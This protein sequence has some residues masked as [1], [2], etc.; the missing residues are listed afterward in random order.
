MPAPI[1]HIAGGALTYLLSGNLNINRWYIVAGVTLLSVLPDIDVLI[2]GMHR[3]FGHSL[4]FAVAVTAVVGG[5]T[6]FSY[7][8][9]FLILLSHLLLDSL[10]DGFNTVSWLF[11]FYIYHSEAPFNDIHSLIKEIFRMF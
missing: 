1:V 7:L 9:T 8:P 4:L 3:G 10:R 2:P 5:I 11:P 6:K